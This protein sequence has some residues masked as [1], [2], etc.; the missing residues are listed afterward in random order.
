VSKPIAIATHFICQL[1]LTRRGAGSNALVALS[2]QHFSMAKA[3]FL[4]V[5]KPVIIFKTRISSGVDFGQTHVISFIAG[6]Y[7]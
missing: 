3:A 6:E 7:V 2:N 5:R 1:P 4:P